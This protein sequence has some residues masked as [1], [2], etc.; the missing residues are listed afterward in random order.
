MPPQHPTVSRIT[1]KLAFSKQEGPR[2]SYRHCR[3]LSQSQLRGTKRNKS[4]VE[5]VPNTCVRASW[6]IPRCTAHDIPRNRTCDR[7]IYRYSIIRDCRWRRTSHGNRLRSW[8]PSVIRQLSLS[9]RRI[10]NY[11]GGWIDG[12]GPV[13]SR[14][15]EVVDGVVIRLKRE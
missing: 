2:V 12:E 14:E 5:R 11:D 15:H 10:Y 9:R 3:D 8:S 1:T 4:N 7:Y 6:R 13:A